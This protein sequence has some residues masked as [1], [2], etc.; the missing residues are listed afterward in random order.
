[1][2]SSSHQQ[3]ND[4]LSFKSS[5][6]YFFKIIL[7]DSIQNGK[8]G[9]PRK[10]VKNYGNDMSSPA[11]LRVPSGVVWK[12]ELTKCD[13]KIW[14]GKGWPE[15]SNHY[16]LELGHLLFFRYDGNSTFHVVIFDRSASEIQYPYT[17]NNRRQ[18]NENLDQTI[19]ESE[20]DN[21]MQIPM[22]I[23]PSRK[24]REK[25]KLR[26]SRP[27][28]MTRS[29]NS[30]QQVRHN[31]RVKSLERA[32]NAFKPENPFFLAVM[33]PSYVGLGHGKKYRLSIPHNF[34]EK[35]LR[36]EHCSVTLCSKSGKTWIATFKQ[37]HIG[38]KLDNAFLQT[39]WGTF[40]RDNNVQVGDVCA[41]EL[42]NSTEISF[43]VLIYKGQHSACKFSPAINFN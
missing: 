10:F 43:K 3:G 31:E 30:A 1:M 24:M 16:S 25:P 21:S 2:A 19:D 35:H 33:Q 38:K 4:H 36:E 42:I 11:M 39:G 8:L 27:H 41:F 9:I 40:V 37:T 17:S 12:V 20:D 6:P 18:S 28:K 26:C 5:S 13:G 34:V 32:S 7:Q 14:L 29:T 15:F 22:N 23:S